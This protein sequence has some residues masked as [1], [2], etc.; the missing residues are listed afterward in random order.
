VFTHRRSIHM[1]LMILKC[2]N[3]IFILF[4]KYYA[5]AEK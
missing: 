5:N 2:N 4:S 3:K 1:G